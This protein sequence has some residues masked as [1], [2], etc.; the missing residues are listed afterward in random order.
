MRN[1]LIVGANRTPIGAM[2]GVF[3]SAS[4]VDLGIAT[5]NEALYRSGAASDQIEEVIYGNVL[6]AGLAA[7]LF[8]L[9][10]FG[11]HFSHSF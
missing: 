2:S 10:F 3:S 6:Q 7:V 8:R 9:E 4:A 11:S 5:A 1:V